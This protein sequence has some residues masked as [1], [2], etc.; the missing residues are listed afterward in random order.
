MERVRR[1][2]CVT[3]LAGAALALVGGAQGVVAQGRDH[4]GK[5]SRAEVLRGREIVITRDC[6]G[7]H[8]ASLDMETPGWL[9]GKM[10][11]QQEFLIGPCAFDPNAKPCFHTRPRNSSSPAR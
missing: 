3:A 10:S 11:P 4:N 6:G 7:C 1:W 5:P 8:S 9:A 2:T